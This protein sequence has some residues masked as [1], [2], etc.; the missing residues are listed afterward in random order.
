MKKNLP[1]LILTMLVLSLLFS[2]LS[3]HS[4]LAYTSGTNKTHDFI[5][6]Q[7][8]QILRNDGWVSISDFLTSIDPSDPQGRTY[9]QVMMAG[10]DEN[11]GLYPP[12]LIGDSSCWN[13]YMDPTDHHGIAYLGVQMKSAGQLCEERFHEALNHWIVDRNWHDAMYDLG[14]ASHLVQDVCV[15]HHA[16]PT[17]QSGHS[18]YETWVENNKGNFAVN[19][20]GI[21]E[22]APFPDSA[23]YT[24]V[25]YGGGLHPDAFDWVDSNAHESIKYWG[26][27]NYYGSNDGNVPVMNDWAT[28]DYFVE[29]VHNLPNNISST[30]IVTETQASQTQI[31]FTKIQMEQNHDYVKI[32]DASDNLIASYTGNQS[33]VWS[34]PVFGNT[35]KIRITTDTSMQSWGYKTDTLKFFDVGHDLAGATNA[36][37][38]RAQQTTAGFIKFFFDSVNPVTHAQPYLSVQPVAIAPLTDLNSSINGLETPPT[39]SPVG[40]NFT[41][42]IH[43]RNATLVNVPAGVAGVELHFYFGNILNY[44]RP[45]GFTDMLGQPGGVLLGP[46]ILYGLGWT[47]FYDYASNPIFAPPYTNATQ[48]IVAAASASGPWNNTDGLVA[49]ITFQ[50]TSQPPNQQSDFYAPLQITRAD[51][52][53]ENANSV[54]SYVIQ[55]GLHIDAL[56]PVHDVA[57]T[58]VLSLRTIIGQG[59][60][61]NITV[62]AADVG[63]SPETSSVTVYANSTI[64]ASQGVTLSAGDFRTLTFTWNTTGFALGNWAV[65]AYAWPVPNETNTANNNCTGGMVFITIPCDLNG[66]FKVSLSDLVTLAQAYGSHCA[67][68]HYQEEPASANWNPNADTNNDGKVDLSDLVILA[69]HYGQPHPP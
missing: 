53:D 43:L 32:Y 29:T 7:A 47:G 22:L 20:G 64:I 39:P 66:D 38:S 2:N 60:G 16:Y 50:I 61:G 58:S 25:H 51:L 5:F 68:Y 27:V 52:Y 59:Y 31:H 63:T 8:N 24:P 9:L 49:E 37:L 12:A 36:L 10:S 57:V 19:S 48:Y 46:S 55:G 69:I 35:L 18:T 30:W 15:P 1:W 62:T 67:D 11:D 6:S 17:W 3:I 4:G 56:V 26:S 33:D 13:H 44:C 40:Q 54:P 21:Y 41:V 14:W 34:P 65:N 45:T 23:Y 28:N 42:E